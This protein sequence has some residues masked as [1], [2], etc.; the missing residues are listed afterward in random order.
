MFLSIFTDEVDGDFSEA[1]PVIAG[2]GVKHCDLRSRVLGRKVHELSAKEL[3]EVRRLLEENGVRLGALQTSLAKVHLPGAERREEERLK[4]EGII[5][6]AEALDCRLVRS[7]NYWQPPR[8]DW[9]ALQGDPGRLQEVLDL[10]APL[11]ERAREAGL[12]LAFE[13]CGQTTGDALAVLD[14]LGVPG[15]GLAWDPH[16]TWEMEIAAAG[17]DD[18]AKIATLVRR[19]K[20][21]HVKAGSIVPEIRDVE[22][23]WKRVLGACAAAGLELPV[24]VETH[25]PKGSPLSSTEA[26]RR[27]VELV[28]ESWPQKPQRDLNRAAAGQGDLERPWFDNPVGFVIVGL[29]MGR[30]RSREL[31][32]TPGCELV[33]VC[34]LEAGRARSVGEDFGV[35]WKTDLAEWLEDDRAEVIF[36][37]TPTGAHE[38][39]CGAALAAGRHALTTKPMEASLEACDRMIER[40]SE[41]GRLLAVD[42]ELR[43]YQRVHEL[44]TAVEMGVFGQ[45]LSATA[46]L[47]ILRT[48]EYFARGG[49]W[50]GT[51]KMDGGGTLSNQAVHNIDEIV[52]VLGAPEE[53]RCDIWTQRHKIEAEDLGVATW[54]YAGG[55]VVTLYATTCFPQKTWYERLEIHGTEAAY[56]RGRGGPMASEEARWFVD[57]KWSDE[58]PVKTERPW[59]NSMDNMAAAVRSGAELLCP[60]GEGRRTQAVLDAM[61]RSAS[62]GG[63]WTA[64]RAAAAVAATV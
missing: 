10:F 28:R 16:I 23:P 36:C 52:H 42:F 19:S 47:K 57:G 14:A 27:T 40:A 20:M 11:A 1:L 50:H 9:G 39:I 58:A 7:F 31:L 32:L 6:A 45:V 51:W 33:G 37:L 63:A 46:Q 35:P 17:R 55:A 15:W 62:N 34:D 56:S 8:E 30:P 53:V 18:F 29:G 26:S 13:N 61:Y 60:A 38:K 3:A 44:K 49:G 5:R 12:V 43:S 59:L 21:I 48:E 24:C 4:L 64:L 41:A 2:W 22:V 25:N 54:R